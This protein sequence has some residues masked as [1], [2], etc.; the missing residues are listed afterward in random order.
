MLSDEIYEI[1]DGNDSGKT[2]VTVDYGQPTNTLGPHA[3]DS[4]Q[5]VIFFPG[6]QELAAH[7]VPDR[8]FVQFD[9]LGEEFEHDVPIGE[10]AHRHPSALYFVD[11]HYSADVVTA[12]ET[13]GAADRTLPGDED[14][15]AIADFSEKHGCLLSPEPPKDR[16][17]CVLRIYDPPGALSTPAGRVAISPTT[18]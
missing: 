5:D 8:D 12:H 9:I 18:A 3:L 13:D 10:D 11:D 15:L 2:P 7:Y 4:D 17:V 6:R 16:L 1:V 14:Y